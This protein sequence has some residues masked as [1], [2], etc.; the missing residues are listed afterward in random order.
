MIKFELSDENWN[1]AKSS[2]ISFESFPMLKNFSNN[3]GGEINEC[4]GLNIV[5]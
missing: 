1:F 3:I 2:P 5:L 4:D